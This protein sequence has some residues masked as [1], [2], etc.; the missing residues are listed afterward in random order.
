MVLFRLAALTLLTLVSFAIGSGTNSI[1]AVF[2][3]I[4][5]LSAICLYFLPS[6]E[7]SFRKHEN[8]IPVAML[9]L[10][11]G[12]TFIGWVV[13][14]IW[15]LKKPLVQ[16]IEPV[17]AGPIL[18]ASPVRSQEATPASSS[19]GLTQKR[20]IKQCPFCAED[21]LVSAIKCK[22]CGSDLSPFPSA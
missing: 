21:V 7:A 3:V 6:I 19:D 11:L 16:Q 12:W 9:N 4:F 5:F 14:Y 18:T 20:E 17:Y 2:A 22:H 15:S 1:A 8:M 13:A 10:L